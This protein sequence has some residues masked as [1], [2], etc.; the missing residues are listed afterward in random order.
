MKKLILIATSIFCMMGSA[1]AA[2]TPAIT[3]DK[4]ERSNGDIVIE[5]SSK[6]L[7]PGTKFWATVTKFNGKKVGAAVV[8]SDNNV[9]IT[10]DKHF[11][12][13]LKRNNGN[14]SYPPA[15]GVYELT[16]HAIFNRAWQEV[17]VLKAVGAVLDDKG[18]AINAEPRLLPASPDL[19][20]EDILG[21]SIR[22]L[23]ATRTIQLKK[24]SS[25]N[26]AEI[27][28]K[29]ATVEIHDANAKNNPILSFDATK[30]SV[31]EAIKKAGR[32]GR[33]RA[34][35]V[36]CHGDF[37]DGMGNRYLSDDLIYADGRENRAFKINDYATIMDVCVTQESLYASRRHK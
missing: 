2:S 29:R 24:I 36:L 30:L 33:G 35:A 15:E 19:V 25:A 27:S 37:K 10:P 18:R 31:N 22:V 9:S 13:T 3:I 34:M 20:K 14:S 21:S 4:A 5:G 8:L 32:I 7:P 23:N 17:E 11:V 6:I 28:T 12:A 1:Q 26:A 16:F